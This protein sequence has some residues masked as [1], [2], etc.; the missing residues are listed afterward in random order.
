MRSKPRSGIRPLP[1]MLVIVAVLLLLGVVG[2]SIYSNVKQEASTLALAKQD[3][4]TGHFAKAEAEL[5]SMLKL[6][7]N[8][9]DAL[10]EL[11]LAQAAQGKNAQAIA[12]YAK[13]VQK[14]SKDDASWYRM[15]LLERLTGLPKQSEDHLQ[16]ALSAKPGN[17]N[18]TDELARTK[19]ALGE[20]EGAAALWGSLAKHGKLS[21]ASRRELL[22]LQA[23]A[24]EAAK[25]YKNAKKSFTEAL[26][27]DPRN[28][29]LA[30]K[31]KTFQ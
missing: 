30:A 24:Y 7:P 19:M 1:I 8:D 26:K 12:A 18:Y 9:L 27:L 3:Y 23:Q 16:Q 13:I 20:F 21:K 14:D 10:R 28:K 29:G 15:A 17:P 22:V 4:E 5:T 2:R 6:S 25:D 11:A 31:V